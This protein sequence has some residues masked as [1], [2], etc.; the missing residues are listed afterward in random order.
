MNKEEIKVIRNKIGENVLLTA[1]VT[2]ENSIENKEKLA[3]LLKILEKSHNSNMNRSDELPITSKIELQQIE[4]VK[5]YI[6][7]LE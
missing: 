5:K 7:L 6:E 3:R 1:G 2:D 4:D